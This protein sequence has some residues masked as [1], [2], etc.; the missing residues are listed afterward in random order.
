M[1]ER[2]ASG[3]VSRGGRVV[4]LLAC[5]ATFGCGRSPAAGPA[6]ELWFYQGV[7]LA[8]A[9]AVQ[10]LAPVWARAARAGYR[11]VV[12]A[13]QKFA[14]LEA[15][16][17]AYFTRAA[18]L[19]ELADSLGLA[20]VPGV[21]QVGRS[22]AMLAGDPNLAE[23]LPVEGV[24]MVVRGGLAR[25]EPD[26]PV[27]FPERPAQRD[28]A[29]QLDGRQATIRE[30]RGR[31]RLVYDVAVRRHACYHVWFQLRTR[32]FAGHPRVWIFGAGQRLHFMKPIAPAATQDWTRFDLLFDSLE[33][34]AVRI[35]FG[36]GGPA[37][38]E[39]AWRDW[40]IEES[41]PVNVVRRRDAPF[42]LR[43]VAGS[44]VLVEGRDFDPVADPLLG[45]DPWPGQFSE[46]HAAPAVHVRRPDG[47]VLE[48]AWQHA[49]IVNGTQVCCC[50][51]Q[52]DTWTRL[53][54]EAR[55]MR[56][57]WGPGR[58]LMMFDEIRALGGDSA[59]V[60]TG[61]GAGAI[62]ADAIARGSAL[63]P[64]DTLYVWG[65]MFDPTQN[66]VNGYYL[67]RGDLRGS[68]G[69]LGARVGILNWNE[70]RARQ[71]LRFF[72]D[73]GEP[74]VI[75]GYYDGAPEAIRR[76][77]EAARGVGGIEAILYATWS[78]RYD[79]LEAFARACRDR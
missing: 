73:R 57:L 63:L 79:D 64:A 27:A 62:L 51:S 31:A 23:A 42:L 76:W 67:V 5:L 37:Q 38:G 26:P 72:A 16:D 78:G 44:R 18:R 60:R 74:Q 68:W 61:R 75:A 15:M 54:D 2:N 13:D 45:R 77:I 3:V 59:C 17:P 53:A 69:G 43:D 14:R 19:R 55:R 35:A 29:V 41:G 52:P 50:L 46:W 25:V 66:A 30:P 1:L 22:G 12:L 48:A 32:D 58:Y 36:V 20:I 4:A 71:S 34:D 8:E 7:N 56:A 10:R 65:D 47:T 49:A 33:H 21:F 11:R 24:R 6:P 70:P 40:G 9:D 28:P 39:V